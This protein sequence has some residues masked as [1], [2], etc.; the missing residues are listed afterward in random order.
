M[1]PLHIVRKH[2][3][4]RF[5]YVVTN[6]GESPSPWALSLLMFMHDELHSFRLLP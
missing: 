1:A 4:N 3:Y 2:L 5:V 6:V